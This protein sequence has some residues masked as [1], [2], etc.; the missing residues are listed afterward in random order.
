MFAYRRMHEY[1]VDASKRK[2]YRKCD[3]PV[4][5]VEFICSTKTYK[6]IALKLSICAIRV[7]VNGISTLF[8]IYI[9]REFSIL[10]I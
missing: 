6:R 7:P 1:D 10:Y 4:N 2:P 9:G 5:F 8:F 3:V